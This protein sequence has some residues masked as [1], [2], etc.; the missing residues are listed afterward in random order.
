MNKL[1]QQ[2]YPEVTNTQHLMSAMHDHGDISDEC[3]L[4]HIF[5]E[6]Q[7]TRVLHIPAGATAVGKVH[8]HKTL[9]MLLK[10]EVLI[11]SGENKQPVRLTAPQ[12]FESNA[13]VRKIAIAITDVI[14]ANVH[15][16]DSKD[17]EDIESQ[18]IYTEQEFL[19]YE[20]QLRLGEVNL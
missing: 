5:T 12:I 3:K 19:E 4:E 15:V 8:K 7:Y 1:V 10:G 20:E 11:Y 2:E 13:G 6:G 18:F 16:T 9:N 14:F 17:L